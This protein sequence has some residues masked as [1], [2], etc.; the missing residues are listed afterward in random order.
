MQVCGLK[1]AKAALRWQDGTSHLM[2]VCG[3]K[4]DFLVLLSDG[5]ASHL[6]Q[7]CGLKLGAVNNFNDFCQVTP[8]AG[9]WI[10]TNLY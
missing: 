4:Q 3:L 7:V 10:E 1:Q 5:K 2:Q 8:H 9:V 6:M